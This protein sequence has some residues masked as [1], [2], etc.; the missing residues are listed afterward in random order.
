MWSVTRA[1]MYVRECRQYTA[2][3]QYT[4]H[5]YLVYD[6][7]HVLDRLNFGRMYADTV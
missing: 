6:S 1:R 2:G 7:Q 5:R 4:M 3:M